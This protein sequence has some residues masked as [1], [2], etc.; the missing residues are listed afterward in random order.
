MR[1][2]ELTRVGRGLLSDPESTTVSGD[3]LVLKIGSG[4]DGEEA[5]GFAVSAGDDWRCS[6]GAG[7]EGSDEGLGEHFDYCLKWY[8]FKKV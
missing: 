6:N 2:L 1:M 5:E 7:E 8:Y 3:D 4:S